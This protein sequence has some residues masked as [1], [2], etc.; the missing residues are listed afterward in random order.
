MEIF[1]GH[2]VIMFGSNDISTRGGEKK[3][4]LI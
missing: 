3:T 2:C 1:D 4:D